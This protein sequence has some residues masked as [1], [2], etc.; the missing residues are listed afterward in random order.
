MGRKLNY[1]FSRLKYIQFLSKISLN[2]TF[3]SLKVKEDSFK[4]L[5]NF[6]KLMIFILRNLFLTLNWKGYL[7]I[8]IL[9]IK[10]LF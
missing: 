8:S 3:N 1:F 9:N 5:R 4:K 7:I 2:T 10:I 6:V